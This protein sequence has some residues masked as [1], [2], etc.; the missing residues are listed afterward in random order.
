MSLIQ[1]ALRR[2]D[3]QGEPSPAVP[4]RIQP[5]AH[6][7]TPTPPLPPAPAPQASKA[8][9]VLAVSLVALVGLVGVA[10]VLLMQSL[11]ALPGRGEPKTRPVAE[12]PAPAGPSVASLPAP[13]RPAE[14]PKPAA[15]APA[16]LPSPAA[17]PPPAAVPA[18]EKPAAAPTVF[19]AVTEGPD[20]SATTVQ[21]VVLPPTDASELELAAGLNSWPRLKVVGVMAKSDVRAG[22]AVMNNT[23]VQSGDAIQGIHLLQ[24][25]QAGVL[26]EY[27]GETQFVR[28]GQVTQ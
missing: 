5:L 14:R 8:W 2:K 28:V 3:D 1:E 9:V 26:L 25:H 7:V 19:E 17:P 16:P 10:A 4:P 6:P 21:V 23:V 11:R 24:V 13:A 12:A 18:A 15:P 20:S 27:H 22:S